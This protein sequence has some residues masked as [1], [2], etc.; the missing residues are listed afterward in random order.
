MKKLLFLIPFASS[1][2]SADVIKS[3]KFEGLIHLSPEVARE[4]SGLNVGDE[5]TLQKSNKA[6]LNLFEQNYF[7]DIY[8]DDND[9]NVVVYLKEKPSI[10]RVELKGVVTNDEKAIKELIDIKPGNMYDELV[11]ERT[12]DKI[13][14][15]YEAKGYFD[16][17]VD[18]QKKQ[19]DSGPSLYLT[20]NINR[21][22][23]LIIQDVKLVGAKKF[24]YSDVE[25]FIAN[26]SK[27]FMGWMWGRN[28]GKTKL[29][30]LPQDPDRIK[31][32]YLE[33]GYLDARVSY[34]FMDAYFDSYTANLTYYIS[35]G[36]PYT[37]SSISIEA[38]ETLGLNDEQIIK[39]MR[40]EVG[41]VING[42]KVRK[43]LENLED[44][45][46]DMGYAYVN[47]SPNTD[48]DQETHK[49][50]LNYVVTPGEKVYIRNVT[51]SGNDRTADRVIRRELYITEGQLYNRT[52][53]RD[54]QDALKRT[55]YFED[56]IIKE[57]RVDANHMDLLVEVKEASTGSISGGIG[58][59]SSDGLLLNASLADS[60]IMGSGL[61]GAISVDRSDN[62]LSGSISLTNPRIFDSRYSLGGSIYAN[63][64]DWDNYKEKSKGFDITL[65]R[66]LTRN[67]SVSLTYALESSNITKLSAVLKAIGYKEGTNL[68]SS[69]TPAIQY[70]STDDYYL[71]RRGIL[72]GSALEFAGV[73]G[74]EKFVKSRSYFN[75]Y[76]G[77]K[78]YIDYDLIFR[79]KSNFSKIFN[80]GYVPINEKLYL[81]GISSIRGYE[82]RSVSPKLKYNG[83]WYET[84]GEAS[85]NNSFEISFPIINRIKMRGVLFY[86]YG[87]IGL[88]NLSDIKRS[89]TGVGVEWVTPIGP[90]QLIFAKALNPAQNDDTSKFEFS[91]GRRF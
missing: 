86:D 9:G 57:Q 65:G 58:Y 64:S 81:G 45:V 80:R 18:V 91:I 68:K 17:V 3:I 32:L 42:Q 36:E 33:K 43:D 78:D 14:K 10:A 29:F 61:K 85:F 75:Y 50:G 2:L 46:A 79:Y 55:S 70:N 89:S 4:I 71:P 7:E 76:L 66:Q 12:I 1:C 63:K 31:E 62:E 22:E 72:A 16:T 87:M 20:L 47:V 51:I 44:I 30:E 19:V 24:D 8:I 11:I 48:K 5:L 35:E 56:V 53:L 37:I 73:G 27:E 15:F 23:N 74:D 67:L 28:D 6:I 90:L 88:N 26:K 82:S 38:P 39:D 40:L 52:D 84:G 21:G 49:V 13:R 83:Q 41:D 69:I 59:G 60:N 54:S 77:L 25:P 34:P